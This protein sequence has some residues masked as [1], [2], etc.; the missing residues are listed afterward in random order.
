MA[1]WIPEA[2]PPRVEGISTDVTGKVFCPCA[3]WT[4]NWTHGPEKDFISGKI[5]GLPHHPH[6]DGK[7]DYK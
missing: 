6:C 4:R 1:T 2:L 7:G 3:T 5:T